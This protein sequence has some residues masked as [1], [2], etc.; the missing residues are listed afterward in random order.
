MKTLLLQVLL[1]KRNQ[2]LQ[3]PLKSNDKNLINNLHNVFSK[4][5]IS[6]GLSDPNG[7]V[8]VNSGT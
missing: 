7:K 5:I 6:T 2:I 3:N 4:K 8:G 1:Q